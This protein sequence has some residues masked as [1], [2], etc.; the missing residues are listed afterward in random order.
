MHA[1]EQ[2]GFFE[3]IA[4]LLAI[5]GLEAAMLLLPDWFVAVCG[6]VF[7]SAIIKFLWF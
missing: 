7:S 5:R 6:F 4:A 3:S 1:L 2:L